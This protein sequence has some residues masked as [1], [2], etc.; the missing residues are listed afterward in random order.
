M[1]ASPFSTT[2]LA[3]QAGLDA[4]ELSRLIGLV[5]RGPLEAT[6]WTELLGAIRERCNASFVSLVLQKP[7]HRRTGLIVNASRNGQHL[8]GE[9]SYS[10][11]YYA[12]CPFLDWPIGQVASADQMMGVQHWLEHGFY[13]QYLQKLDLR[14]VLATNLR[15]IG[16]MHCGL[17]ACRDHAAVDFDTADLALVHLLLPHLQ[18]ALDLHATIDRSE[19][20]RRLYALTIDRLMVGTVI[21]DT[22]GRLLRSNSAAQRLLDRGDGLEHRHERLQAFTRPDNRNLQKAIQTVLQHGLHHEHIEVIALTRPSGA[23]PLNLLL[24]PIPQHH[25]CDS[26][27]RQPAVAVFIRDPADSPKAS[28]ILLRSLFHLTRTETDVAIQ[29]MD[30]LTLD[31]TAGALGVSRN[32]VRTHLRGVFAKTGVTRQ[33]ELV[34]TLLNSVASLA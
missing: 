7:G 28:H 25:E 13:R 10:E 30:G 11:H 26:D 3:D 19:S 16:G 14:Y 2:E 4:A 24:R 15:S 20:E 23:M 22:K 18:Q 6:P 21:L 32:T 12:F 1:I 17:F 29:M 5:Y 31:E 34:K 27:A 33:A 8:P 9:P